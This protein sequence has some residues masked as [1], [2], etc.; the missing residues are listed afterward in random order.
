MAKLIELTEDSYAAFCDMAD[1][2]L[3]EG[4]NRYSRHSSPG[5]FSDYL[6]EIERYKNPRTVPVGMVC[7]WS[8]FLQDHDG[9]LLGGIRFR[10]ELN[11][12][13]LIEGGNIGYDIRPSARNQGYATEML[14]MVL[15]IA[16]QRKMRRLLVT[17][18]A[19]NPASAR[20]ITKCGGVMESIER[21]P[22]TGKMTERYWI[23]L[24]DEFTLEEP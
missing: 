21:S 13:L 18:F 23:S 10:P 2:F 1:D 12:G 14:R 20:V 6:A 8:R 15:D 11:A 3:A 4:D 16:R 9:R 19:D 17:C 7:S 24:A 22:R 5:A